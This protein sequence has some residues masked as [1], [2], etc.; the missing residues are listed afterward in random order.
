MAATEN[1][2]L[3]FTDLV[4]STE[5]SSSLAPD[6]GDEVRRAYF[7]ALREAIAATGGNEVKNLGDGL[8]VGFDATI[9]ALSCAVAMQQVIERH[10]R[11]APG[12]SSRP[13]AD[14]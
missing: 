12:G 11:R 7:A 3:L 13:R 5:L 4:G 1:V 14:A 2:T 10:N 8:M 6:A 9:S